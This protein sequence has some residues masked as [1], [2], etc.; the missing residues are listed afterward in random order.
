V[1][2][3]HAQEAAIIGGLGADAEV[4]TQL[5]CAEKRI[6]TLLAC[7]NAVYGGNARTKIA[8]LRGLAL[9]TIAAT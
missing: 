1:G 2:R 8:P 3:D 4:M 6:C 5:P 9:K 7:T